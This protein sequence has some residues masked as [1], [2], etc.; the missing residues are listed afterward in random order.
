MEVADRRQRIGKS[1]RLLKI[2]RQ[3]R[4]DGSDLFVQLVRRCG[5]LDPL[6]FG[7]EMV[8]GFRLLLLQHGEGIVDVRQR[9]RCRVHGSS[10]LV[11]TAVII[12]I[13]AQERLQ[14]SLGRHSCAV[15]RLAASCSRR[16]AS[17]AM[18]FSTVWAGSTFS[19]SFEHCRA[20]GK[21]TSASW[22]ARSALPR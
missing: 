12:E 9:G 7:G 16:F 19:A 11:E 15:T 20:A 8:F 6:A 18:V 4:F 2:A 13:A 10:Q 14:T 17:E 3:R 1:A 21:V 22:C 5:T